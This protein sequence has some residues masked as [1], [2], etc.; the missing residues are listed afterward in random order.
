MRATIELIN[1][2]TLVVHVEDAD[3]FW[4]LKSRLEIPLE[5]VAGARSAVDEA[6]DW[7][8]GVRLG[9][10]HIPGVISAGR[11]YG[12]GQMV[13]WDVHDPEKAIGV[14]LRDERYSR[15][16]LEVDDPEGDIPRIARATT[17]ISA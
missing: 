10:T 14:E 17:A 1:D 9:G 12:D 7:L 5:H 3:R 4:A 11:F 6:R 2:D 15:L 16:V 8:H 13:F